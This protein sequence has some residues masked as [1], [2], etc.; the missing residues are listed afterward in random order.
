MFADAS[1]IGQSKFDVWLMPGMPG[2]PT[3]E[4]KVVLDI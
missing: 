2:I 3:D 1:Q 4:Q